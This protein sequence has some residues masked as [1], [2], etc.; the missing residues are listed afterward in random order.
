[1]ARRRRSRSGHKTRPP[2]ES[3]RASIADRTGWQPPPSPLSR[4][5]LPSPDSR[6]KTVL[7]AL[8]AL[9]SLAAD[10][11]MKVA[12]HPDG[13]VELLAGQPSTVVFHAEGRVRGVFVLPI[14]EQTA[15]KWLGMPAPQQRDRPADRLWEE[16]RCPSNALTYDG[17]EDMVL[18]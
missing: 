1:M 10:L 13:Q 3:L 5:G 14:D 7:T 17:E 8:A 9:P 18:S 12:A 2:S 16:D 15:R 4:R 6:T 11:G